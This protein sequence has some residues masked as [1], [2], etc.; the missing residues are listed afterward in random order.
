MSEENKTADITN[1]SATTENVNQV[2]EG[3]ENATT[4]EVQGQEGQIDSSQEGQEGE[5]QEADVP[6]KIKVGDE[7]FTPEQIKEWKEWAEA[8]KA[9]AEK[10]TYQPREIE[11]IEA[12]ITNVGKN[13]E[14]DVALLQKTFLA[15][16]NDIVNE[17]TGE[18]Q[19]TAQQLYEHGMQ[20]GQ[21]DYFISCLSP[22]DAVA[23]QNERA[24]IAGEYSNKLDYLNQ[25][26]SYI[27]S[28]KA[29]KEDL[30]K[31]DSYISA[32]TTMSEAEKHMFNYVKNN[33]SFDEAGCKA[34]QQELR[35]A[36]AIE[37][38]KTELTEQNNSAKASM[39]SSSISGG[40][41]L[42]GKDGIPNT[43]AEIKEK[44]ESNP[45]WY[46][47]NRAEIF[48]RNAKGLIK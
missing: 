20:T 25:E 43:W 4:E 9:E 32:D 8:K 23:F 36:I 40:G 2:T 21:W 47:K 29:K 22:Q 48:K 26:K 35:K 39:M 45:E 18:T 11:T 28:I 15:K 34:F 19:Y 46:E 14:A 37:R 31:W 27:E 17:E 13:I 7:E 6:E 16:A 44:G 3:N 5:H 24:K 12:D 38:N 1:N 33:F 41:A 42:Q 30:T 10:N